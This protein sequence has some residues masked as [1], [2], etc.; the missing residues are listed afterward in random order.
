[1][2]PFDDLERDTKAFWLRKTHYNCIP[3]WS[4]ATCLQYLYLSESTQKKLPGTETTGANKQAI[5]D[6]LQLLIKDINAATLRVKE[7]E[8]VID[9]VNKAITSQLG[10]TNAPFIANN[11]AEPPEAQLVANCSLLLRYCQGLQIALQ[12]EKEKSLTTSIAKSTDPSST[13]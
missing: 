13:P 3:H 10:I 11:L 1:M 9:C 6:R 7:L 2:D 5:K 8:E 4:L 12:M